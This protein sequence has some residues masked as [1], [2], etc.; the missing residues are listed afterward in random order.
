MA[1]LEQQTGSLLQ[2]T[3]HRVP[4]MYQEAFDE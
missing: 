1:A 2:H 4:G 3:R